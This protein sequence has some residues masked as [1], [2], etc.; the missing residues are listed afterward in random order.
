MNDK[1]NNRMACRATEQREAIQA[2][3]LQDGINV[4]LKQAA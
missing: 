3:N 4:P 1:P 2:A